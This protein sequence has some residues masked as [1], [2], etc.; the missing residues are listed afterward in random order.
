MLVPLP[1]VRHGGKRDEG[2]GTQRLV[3]DKKDAYSAKGRAMR[4][5]YATMRWKS[6][7][8]AGA[9]ASANKTIDN[10]EK[11]QD[12]IRMPP[13]GNQQKQNAAQARSRPP[14]SLYTSPHPSPAAPTYPGPPTQHHHPPCHLP[15]PLTPAR[16]PKVLTSTPPKAPP[17]PARP[18][19]RPT[20]SPPPPRT[21]RPQ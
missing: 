18:P 2:A 17:A 15:H 6:K 14:K 19:P 8:Y 13:R 11:R 16:Y 7:V 9:A 5:H 21:A 10:D 4:F 20:P 3:V 1:V 12:E